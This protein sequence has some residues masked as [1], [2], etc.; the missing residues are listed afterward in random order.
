MNRRVASALT[1]LL[2]GTGV[3]GAQPKKE[4]PKAPAKGGAPAPAPTPTPAPGEKPAGGEPVTMPEDPP[5]KD[6][7]GKDENPDTPRGIDPD[8]PAVVVPAKAPRSGYPIEEV[9]RPITLPE[10][11]S[12]VS[13]GPHL[14][15]DNFEV[16]DALRARY[17]ITRQIQ[18]GLTYVYAG[19]YNDPGTTKKDY[20]VHGGKAVGLD[21]TYLIKDWIGVKVGVP[22]YIDPLAVGLQIGV[23]M[24]FIFAEKFSLG[25][26]DDLL[27][28]DI[29]D[30]FAP[31]L[32]S[33]QQNAEQAFSISS[34]Q[35]NVNSRGAL[36]FSIYGSYQ[37]SPK[38]ALLGR[39]GQR[40]EDFSLGSGG[41]PGASSSID[42]PITY[43][44]V[45][46][47]YSV[48]KSLDVGGSI[49]FESLA[50]PG[51]FGPQAF[52]NFRI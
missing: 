52:I 28:V 35:N 31:S 6:M 45:G 7:E 12:E 38:L 26:L 13:I 23:P 43:I 10:N 24:K 37:Q 47:L 14:Q 25:A 5:P 51:T 44:R 30:K 22:V 2:A 50:E 39:I 3:V 36:R 16:T 4:E 49:G 27:E 15:V 1:V 41:T 34:G 33:E 17:G 21:V 11:V 19:V 8:Q 9:L 40:L 18:I 29:S 42:G 46:L 48:M 32:Y 20:A